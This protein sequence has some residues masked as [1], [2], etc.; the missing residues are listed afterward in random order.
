VNGQVVGVLPLVHL[1]FPGLLSEM[2]ALPF[3]D[4]GNCLADSEQV[5]DALLRDALHLYER[6]R[7][8]KMSLRGPLL[9]TEL[10]NT[11]FH[12]QSLDKV[13]MLMDLPPS[14]DQ[15]LAGFKSKLRSQINKAEK[16]GIRFVWGGLDDLDDI[17]FVF[18]KNMHALGSPVH[19]KKWLHSIVSSYLPG[20]KIG[21]A[22]FEGK[23]VG[24]GF[25]L[26][27]KLG[28]SLPWASTLREY[29]HLGPNMLL[30]WKLLEFSADN[31]FKYFDFGRSTENEGT[32]NFKKQWGAVPQP[33][34][35]YTLDD[36][37]HDKKERL[38]LYKN[39]SPQK[40]VFALWQRMPLAAANVLGPCLRKYISL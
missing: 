26:L 5:Q 13:R 12:G 33:L 37:V 22:Q 11:F 29:N 14:S 19:A 28:V 39:T 24:V 3:C 16:N 1:H 40:A 30:Y 17:Y 32:Y 15:L 4:V 6:L 9:E 10:K 27:G 31:G 25:I 35:W 38:P 8:T 36:A 18:S 2:A 7:C 21:L 20:I 23:A 34:I